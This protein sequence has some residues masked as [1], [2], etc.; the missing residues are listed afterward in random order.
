[1][2]K[3][4][5]KKSIMSFFWRH[6]GQKKWLVMKLTVLFIF[7]FSFTLVANTSAQQERVNLNLKNVSIRTL[8]GEIQKQTALSFVY[9]MELTQH[10]GQVS[11]KAKQEAVESV[12]NRVLA[13]TGLSYKF[14]GDIIVICESIPTQPVQSEQKKEIVI[15]GKVVDKDSMAI[16]GATVL[17][18]GTTLGTATDLDGN[19]KLTVPSAENI[20]LEFSFVGMKK[21]FVKVKGLSNPAPLKVVMEDEAV[22]VDEVVVVGYGVTATRD[23]TGQVASLN[24]EQLSKKSATNVETMLQNAAAGVVVSLASSNPSEKI[25]VR[26]R[27]EASLTGDNEP[28]YVVDGMPVTSDVMSAISPSDIQSMDVLKDAS[29]AAIYGSRGANGVV[30]VTTKRGKSGK[31]DLNVNYAFSV[32]SRINNFSTLDG[33]EFRE[34]V[35]YVAEQTLKVDPSNKTANSILKEGSTD[36]KSGNTDWYKE[37]KRPSHRHDLNLSVRG[38]G[39]HSNYYIS[40]GVLDYQGMV[41]HDDFTRYTG[42]I[43]LDYDITDFLKFGTSTTLGYTD[44][45]SPG[46]SLYTA[47]GFRPDYPIYNEDG[48]YYKEGNSYNPVAQNDAKSYNDNYS[49]LSTSFL[50]LNIWKGL[51]LKTTLSLNQNMSYSE[52]YK[53]TYLT[54]DNKGYGT[55][56]TSR[57]FTTVFDN[58]LSWVGRINDIHALDAVVGISFE[59]TKRRGFGVDAKN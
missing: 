9:N 34:Y 54:S 45:S 33:D 44:V 50:E 59:R 57:S 10:L 7:V 39:E 26:V 20:E 1:M 18:K 16:I 4:M 12:L 29:A 47:I 43:N 8:F 49:I 32:D 13:N 5:E 6:R 22:G 27:G 48:S 30:I 35:R 36:L 2:F 58:T 41:E 52:S 21:Q 46:I 14:E 40:L 25:R 51:K 15:E 3:V 17:V 53:P 55:E 31:P 23:L 19:F 42:R 37:L 56:S 11:V 24:E 38:G 28:L